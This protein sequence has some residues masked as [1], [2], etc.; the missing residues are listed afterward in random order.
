[1]LMV[2]KNKKLSR[3]DIE[4]GFITMIVMMIIIVVAAIYLAYKRVSNT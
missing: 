3:K 4:Q 2:N 1:M